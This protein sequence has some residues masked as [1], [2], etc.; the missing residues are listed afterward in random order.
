[1]WQYIWGIVSNSDK[2]DEEIPLVPIE[3]T[4]TK[5]LKKKGCL[6]VVGRKDAA[7]SFLI[8]AIIGKQDMCEV[9]LPGTRNA[10]A[11]ETNQMSFIE[12][13]LPPPV[14]EHSMAATKRLI[15]RKFPLAVLYCVPPSH[16]QEKYVLNDS[17]YV[18][19]LRQYCEEKYK[20]KP[21]IIVVITKADE[22][23]KEHPVGSEPHMDALKSMKV[24]LTHIF[25]KKEVCPIKYLQCASNSS[26]E[27]SAPLYS[28]AHIPP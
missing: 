17:Y 3:E 25:R 10:T 15:D 4:T 21:P 11:Y 24:T 14:D 18:E 5:E 27:G 6:L 7:T 2:Q 1:M 20:C 22:V 23:C 16:I 12:F 28:D 13:L 19:E 8:K 26:H 9:I